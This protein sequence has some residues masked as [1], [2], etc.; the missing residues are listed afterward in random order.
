SLRKR[1]LKN[2]VNQKRPNRITWASRIPGTL[3]QADRDFGKRSQTCC[4]KVQQ[5]WARSSCSPELEAHSESYETDWKRTNRPISSVDPFLS[6]NFR[7]SLCSWRADRG[8][9]WVA[10]V[11]DSLL[12][13]HLHGVRADGSHA[14]QPAR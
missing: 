14:F 5:L 11:K 8:C 3:C 12:S 6:Y 10:I 7:A 2:R 4:R 1:Q 9:E 13:D